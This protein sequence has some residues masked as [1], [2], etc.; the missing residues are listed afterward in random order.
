[1]IE[2]VMYTYGTDG[3]VGIDV[4]EFDRRLRARLAAEFPGATIVVLGGPNSDA[5]ATK[6]VHEERLFALETEVYESMLSP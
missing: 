5:S 3:L 6:G 1:M 2:R 4:A